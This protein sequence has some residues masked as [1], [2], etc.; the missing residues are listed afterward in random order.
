MVLHVVDAFAD[1]PFQG[2]PAAVTRLGHF[3]SD[4]WLQTVAREMNLSETAF[5]VRRPDG[6][7]DLRWFTPTSEVD[8]CGH[9]TLAAAHL[10][11]VPA[12]FHT[13]SGVLGCRRGDDGLI[14]MDFPA[15]PTVP[16]PR[17]TALAGADVRNCVRG[18]SDLLVELSDAAA[19]R[20]FRPD[21][22]AIAALDCRA[23]IVTAPGDRPD[24]D[25]VSRVFCPAVGVPEDPVT[26]SAHCT[27]AGY[28]SERSS[29][30][31]MVGYQASIRGGSVRMRL[32]GDRVVLGGRAVT[33][34]EVRMLVEPG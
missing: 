32:E 29:S 15:D 26:G 9:A 5:V 2:N 6:D 13:R 24:V 7:L 1:A 16:V 27:L 21:L 8:L 23:L 17:P 30:S 28:W 4:R 34:S 12:R 11:G 14:E 25:C 22:A 10:I 33:V 19:V 31:T 3:P 18:R 20:A